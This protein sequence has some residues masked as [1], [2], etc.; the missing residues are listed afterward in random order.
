MLVEGSK[1]SINMFFVEI[2]SKLHKRDCR[3][4]QNSR[5]VCPSSTYQTTL[6]ETCPRLFLD[7]GYVWGSSAHQAILTGTCF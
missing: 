3:S 4:S 7:P 6:T 2:C 1:L 5:Y